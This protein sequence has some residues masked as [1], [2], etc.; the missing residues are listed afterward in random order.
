LAVCGLLIAFA[1][2]DTDGESQEWGT[3]L[4]VG[5]YRGVNLPD[6]AER[7]AEL[8]TF[9]NAISSIAD[10]N[11]GT[12]DKQYLIV[13]GEDM[14]V[15]PVVLSTD[16]EF[17]YGNAL[18]DY[19]RGNVKFENAHITVTG[20]AGGIKSIKPDVPPNYGNSRLFTIEGGD[21]KTVT[22]ALGGNIALK[23]KDVNESLV[24]VRND[25][26][27]E[28][29]A[30]A[31]ITGN[32]SASGC[33][34]VHMSGNAVFTMNDAAL[35]SGNTTSTTGGGVEVNGTFTMN[36][37]SSV[38]GNT[39]SNC[40]GGVYVKSGSFTMNGASTVSGNTAKGVWS[41][42]DAAGSGGAGVFVNSDALFT[43]ND[44]ASVSGNTMT[45]ESLSGGGV[46]VKR[47]WSQW[48]LGTLYEWD[49]GRF[50]M[51][52]NAVI[53]GNTAQHGGGLSLY[54]GYFTMNGGTIYGTDSAM[55]NKIENEG[56]ASL[57]T[58]DGSALYGDGTPLASSDETLHGR[59]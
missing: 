37:A 59:K 6:D 52:D 23:G 39:A 15:V 30:N 46:F 34:A 35:I 2:C 54:G 56:S 4:G 47:A 5:V 41:G 17:V 28:M 1:A 7:F 40:G 12:G 32:K 50:V 31:S 10:D 53:G 19:G 42:G 36:G 13:I 20:T 33:G 9:N 11:N 48:Y 14:A 58:T 44:S 49:A 21:G 8:T 57:F 29:N 51:N 55:S 16:P 43:M 18:Y 45:H 27:L 26:V 22:L 25:G 38:S 3:T 24:L